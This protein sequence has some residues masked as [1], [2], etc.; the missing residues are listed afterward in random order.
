MFDWTGQGFTIITFYHYPYF[1]KYEVFITPDL[2]RS[3]LNRTKQQVIF[4]VS[5][6]LE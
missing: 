6:N 4:H 5:R 2:L 1:E 3:K